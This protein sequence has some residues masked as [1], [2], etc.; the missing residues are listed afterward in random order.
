MPKQTTNG[1]RKLTLEEV[2]STLQVPEVERKSIA[3]TIRKEIT[4]LE[5]FKKSSR[6][7]TMR[8]I[9]EV[10]E[11]LLRNQKEI[12]NKLDRVRTE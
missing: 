7:Q 4:K 1:I 12:L 6:F 3:I 2:L 9:L 10:Q 11:Q 8:T 5:E